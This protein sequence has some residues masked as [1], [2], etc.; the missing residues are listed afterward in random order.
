LRTDLLR[1]ENRP[2]LRFARSHKRGTRAFDR[3]L[4]Q[5]SLSSKTTAQLPRAIGAKDE[6][7][8]SLTAVANTAFG[9]VVLA[10]FTGALAWTTSG[11]VRATWEL[12][13]LTRKDQEER[14]RPHVLIYSRALSTG[15]AQ[16]T[17]PVGVVNAGL[18]PAL[19]LRSALSM[20]GRE[21]RK[22]RRENP[23]HQRSREADA[24][25]SIGVPSA[26]LGGVDLLD[27]RLE[28][29]Y[30]DMAQREFYPVVDLTANP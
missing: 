3:P 5:R 9:T 21:R 30:T 23:L 20:T 28:G 14:T 10:G 4:N 2:G 25:I 16:G 27:F 26:P 18:G 15:G 19:R 11:D 29:S 22:R 8:W 1:L 24:T 17:I 12:A 13:E 7:D 6:F